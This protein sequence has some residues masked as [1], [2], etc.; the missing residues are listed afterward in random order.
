MKASTSAFLAIIGAS[1]F[2]SLAPITSKIL[3]RSFE[4]MP[5]A[6]LRVLFASILILP[7]FFAQRISLLKTM[8]TVWPYTIFSALNILFFYLG[9]IRTTVDSSVIIYCNVP[10]VTA[11][12]SYFFIKERL[13]TKKQIGILVGFLGI[14]LVV[15]LP[16][17][18]KGIKTGDLTGNLLILI[19]SFMWAIHG[20]LSKKIIEKGFSPITVSTISFIV[21][22]IIL[23]VGSLFFAKKNFISPI[24][25]DN[26]LF[27]LLLLGLVSVGGYI[28]MQWAIKHTSA[29]ITSLSQYVQP[30]LAIPLAALFLDEKITVEF[31]IGSALVLAGVFI[32]TYK[33]NSS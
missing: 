28:L 22:T 32:A 33:I 23:L 3:Y 5:L 17:F 25:T 29:T 1:L 20:I 10:L 7:I 13:S 16:L 24:F 18:Q 2:F 30:I 12:L 31:L 21:A 4:P 6:F 14:I 26:N 27:F 9:L 8:K 15:I 19:A 11:I